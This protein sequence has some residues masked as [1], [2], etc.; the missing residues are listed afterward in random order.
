VNSPG[1]ALLL[2]AGRVLAV[3]VSRHCQFYF[4]VCFA[5]L[6]LNGGLDLV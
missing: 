6:L 2:Y 1:I 3:K 5:A 4:L